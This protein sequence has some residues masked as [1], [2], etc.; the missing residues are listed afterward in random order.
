MFATPLAEFDPLV[1]GWFADTFSGPTPPQI[2]GWRAI[3]AGRDALIAAPT[4]SGKTLA[5]FL[6]AIDRLVRAIVGVELSPTRIEGKRKLSQEKSGDDKAGVIAALE[7]SDDP[8]DR[9]VADAMK[10][11]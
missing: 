5:A 8:R 4:G 11:A 3:A 6:W 7:A 2:D 1:A 9:A 10:R